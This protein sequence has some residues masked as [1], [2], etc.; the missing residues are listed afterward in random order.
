MKTSVSCSLIM[1]LSSASVVALSIAGMAQA[2]PA[3]IV[4][5]EADQATQTQSFQPQTVTRPATSG[6]QSVS[7]NG[8]QRVEFQ[9][10]GAAPSAPAPQATAT[11]PSF[12]QPISF[13]AA[14]SMSAAPVLTAPAAAAP[15]LAVK[16]APTITLGGVQASTMALDVASDVA[17]KALPPSQPIRI[18]SVQPQTAQ[19]TGQPLTLSRVKADRDASISEETGRASVYADGFN[20]QPTANGEIFDET[21][22]TAAHPSL[23]LPSLVQVVNEDNQREV[24]VRVNDRGPFDGQRILEL[25]PRAGSV[26]GINQGGTANVRVRYL[27]PAPV[28]RADQGFAS[29]SVEDEALPPVT[30]P[31][32][33]LA[34]APVAPPVYTAPSLPAPTPSVSV[35]APVAT[36]NVYIQAGAFV[37]IANAQDLTASLGR[38]MAV[39]IEEARVNGGDFF[40]VL[41]GPYPTLEAAEIQRSQLARAGIADGF[42][43]RR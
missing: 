10:P 16:S 36:G 15:A 30:A 1:A 12:N 28:K 21:A 27:G 35:A 13:S 7:V 38:G 33:V 32:P 2:A 9:Y 14:P 39:K 6:P 17:Q 37:D 25:S 29:N 4:Y 42:L 41:I 20:G 31:E 34:A 8:Q 23:P 18:A 3:P 24:V 22:M 40:R 19:R 11:A 5:A 26:L 43:T